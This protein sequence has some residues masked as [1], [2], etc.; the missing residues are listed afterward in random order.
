M[1]QAKQRGS[2]EERKAQGIE[3]RRAEE[4]AAQERHRE[5]TRQS[6]ERERER[7]AALTDEQREAE[8]VRKQKTAVVT[9]AALGLAN[10]YRDQIQKWN[11]KGII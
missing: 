8:D 2:F 11:G 7:R 4:E 10:V 5:H 3:R 9:G 1:G 6:K